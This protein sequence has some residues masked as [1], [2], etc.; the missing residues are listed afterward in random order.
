MTEFTN[1]QLLTIGRAIRVALG[2]DSR[3]VKIYRMRHSR[4][5]DVQLLMKQLES[6]GVVSRES[7]GDTMG[8]FKD[9]TV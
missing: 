8:Q 5:V 1:S 4:Y 7:V 3:E 2:Y 6:I 9:P